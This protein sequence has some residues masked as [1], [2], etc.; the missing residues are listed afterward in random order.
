MALAGGDPVTRQAA[1]SSLARI[2]S[3]T[4]RRPRS[5]APMPT[6]IMLSLIA[7]AIASHD[8]AAQRALALLSVSRGTLDGSHR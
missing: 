7:V 4:P 5:C 6:A 1:A 8:E 3:S 2:G